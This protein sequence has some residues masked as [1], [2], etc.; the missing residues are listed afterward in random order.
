MR[1]KKYLIK[2]IKALKEDF[3]DILF[4]PIYSKGKDMMFFPESFEALGVLDMNNGINL[5]E[6]FL[7]KG[8]IEFIGKTERINK[9]FAISFGEKVFLKSWN[10][11]SSFAEIISIMKKYKREVKL[12]IVVDNFA[13]DGKKF[14]SA[15]QVL[16][17]LIYG[18]EIA[19]FEMKEFKS[20]TESDI[21]YNIS[22]III[23]TN[24][25]I[26]LSDKI[27][28]DAVIFSKWMNFCRYLGN[29][30]SNVLYPESFVV[31]AMEH[32]D[33]L[34]MMYEIWNKRRIEELGLSGVL[35]VSS[36]S[37][38]EPRF[39]KIKYEGGGGNGKKIALVGK[40]VCFDSGGI[41]LKTS[42]YIY[43]MKYDMLGAS[44]VLSLMLYFAES[45]FAGDVEAYI[46]LVE[47]MPSGSAIKP[48]DIIKMANGK[49]VEIGN[50]DAEGRLILADALYLA[51]SDKPNLIMDFATLTGAIIIALG[52]EAIGIMGNNS[53]FTAELMKAGEFI[54]ERA[55]ELPLWNE[56]KDYL[57]SN[58]ADINNI[59]GR[60]GGS[61]T[62]GIFLKEFVGDVPWI[63]LDIA[64]TAWYEKG[65]KPFGKMATSS[66]MRI[67]KEF[68]KRF[69]KK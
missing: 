66:G 46:P 62:A 17:N 60:A 53:E 65:R 22:D 56:Y 39:L 51:S 31:R 41:N 16:E 67:T 35:S 12:G 14:F 52:Y 15:E 4:L 61:I 44:A 45:N 68:L 29:L 10:L 18:L 54:G 63:H 37:I 34:G 7:K 40:G 3:I 33:R 27:L 58:I 36:G 55:W 48:G 24:N 23:Y 21:S 11:I 2:G 32:L 50:T 43:D 25:D 59:G 9:I 8:D 26:N 69:I 1:E 57:K 30:P 64:G 42:D 28:K 47:N 5:N 49:F 38:H 6:L 19:L 13:I 20:K